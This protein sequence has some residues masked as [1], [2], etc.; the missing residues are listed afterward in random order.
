VGWYEISWTLIAAAAVG[1]VL[2]AVGARVRRLLQLPCPPSLHGPVDWCVGSWTAGAGVLA[3]GLA[4]FLQPLPVLIVTG[5]LAACGRFRELGRNIRRALPFLAAAVPLLAIALAPP[6]FYDAWVY[7]LGLPWQALEEG[8]IRAHPENVFAAYPPLAQLVYAVPL[9]IELVRVPAV[10]HL[11]TSC[12]GAQAVSALARRLGAR[13]VPAT[14]AGLFFL[15]SPLA[16]AV[17]ALPAAESWALTGTVSAAALA[18]TARGRGATA[19]AGL[20][21]GVALATRLQAL[22]WTAMLGFVAVA[23]SRE[24]LRAAAAFAAGAALGSLPWWLKNG[25]LLSDPF[26]PIGWR[27]EGIETMWRDAQSLLYQASGPVDLV[28]Q[29]WDKVASLP[30]LL[31]PPLVLA[32]AGASSRRTRA[33]L[34]AAGLGVAGIGVWVVTG[35]IGRFLLPAL[36]LLLAVAVAARP[37]A[38]AVLAAAAIAAGI[39]IGVV[40]TVAFWERKGGLALLGDADEVYATELVSNPY[41]A[42]SACAELPAGARILMTGEPRGFLLPRPFVTTSQCDVSPL[43]DLLASPDARPAA[44]A[45]E[46]RRR[47]FTHLLINVA[48]MERLGADYPVL[49]WTDEASHDRAA[50]LWAYLEPPVVREGA[51]VVYALGGDETGADPP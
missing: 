39:A 16:F 34:V 47:G 17:P 30:Q 48:E 32:L 26:A 22:A 46:L 9:S 12:L 15:Y 31:L 21:V 51:V 38:H 49:P 6:F 25:V 36:A 2:P 18:L 7:H 41:P 19:L 29:A 50:K 23:A 37:R 8:A 33:S 24:R 4:G 43:R 20:A 35:S 3:C 45:A 5:A 13:R 42:F 14:I 10:L 44:V 40:Q 27:R 1:V 28:V 11:L